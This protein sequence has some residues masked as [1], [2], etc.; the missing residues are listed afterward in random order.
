M[1]K[2]VFKI[3]KLG[4]KRRNKV[5]KSGKDETIFL[6]EIEE[7]LKIGITNAD[8]MINFFK[9]QDFLDKKKLYDFLSYSKNWG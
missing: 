5:N 8:K 2:D 1:A 3:S 6:S 4:L 7:N 9:K